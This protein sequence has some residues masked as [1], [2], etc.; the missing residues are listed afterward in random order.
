MLGSSGSFDPNSFSSSAN[1]APSAGSG[2][3][4]VQFTASG[5]SGLH[6]GAT[7]TF[8]FCIIPTHAGA[9]WPL[10]IITKEAST[11]NVI[12]DD[13]MTEPGCTPP[14]TLDS[15]IHHLHS[16]NCADTIEIFNRNV[17][18]IDTIEVIPQA[19]VTIAGA[20]IAPPWAAP[21][22]NDS[23]ILT[24]STIGS[25]PFSFVVN[26]S[27]ETTGAPFTVRVRTIHGT[28]LSLSADTQL[29]CSPSGVVESGP[30]APIDLSIM[31]NPLRNEANISLSTGDA[32]H[33]DLVLLNVL[34]Q[35][36]RIV[37]RGMIAAGEHDFTLDAS[38]L[39]AGT[40][41]L[42][43]ELNGQVITKKLVIE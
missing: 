27:G 10:A 19:P 14:V 35:T 9:S 7:D 25:A 33:A 11:D 28:S 39:P 6:P 38:A 3:A 12:T 29:V 37:E 8:N 15:I 31:P 20:S 16:S 40:Y 34:G 18:P 5:G 1:W 21:I 32:G 22:I 36:A 13:T 24:G 30:Q 2:D 4:S 17:T 42:R 23:V 41:Y 26:Y 43:L